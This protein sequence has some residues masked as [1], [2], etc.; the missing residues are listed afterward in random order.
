M[1]LNHRPLGPE[2]SA[3][4]RLRYAPI[5]VVLS[6]SVSRTKRG[7]LF[8]ESCRCR[9]IF[10]L[11]RI[12]AWH[13]LSNKSHLHSLAPVSYLLTGT[14]CVEF[15]LDCKMTARHNEHGSMWP[16][17]RSSPRPLRQS[18]VCKHFANGLLGMTQHGTV[19]A[20]TTTRLPGY[21]VSRNP[22]RRDGVSRRPANARGERK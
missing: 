8:F 6:T 2:P 4:T 11:P 16:E 14:G 3:L 13:R 22:I 12:R 9:S 21:G 7:I 18:V 17:V 19:P 15:G 1:D 5:C 20:D 10:S